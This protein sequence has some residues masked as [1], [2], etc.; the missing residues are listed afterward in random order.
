MIE[1]ILAGLGLALCVLLLLRMALP[2][3]PRRRLDA[4]W[5]GVLQGGRHLGRRVWHGRRHRQRA[6]REAEDAIRRAQRGARRDGN[7]VRPESFKGP[8]EPH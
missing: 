4:A 7:V 6:A 8:D 3:G 2:E 5:R 1:R